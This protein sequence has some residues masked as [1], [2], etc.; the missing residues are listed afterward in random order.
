VEPAASAVRTTGGALDRWFEL[1]SVVPLTGF[2]LVHVGSYASVLFGAEELGARRSPSAV[3][4]VAE[5]LFVWLPFAFHIVLAPSIWSRRGR[6]PAAL[7]SER[8]ALALH[9]GA[10]VVLGGFL[11]DHFL[12]FRLPILRGERYPA[13]ALQELAAELSRTTFGVPL[14]AGLHALGVC[15]L[16]FHLAYGLLRIASR[17]SRLRAHQGIVAGVV[18]LALGIAVLGLL[19]VIKLAGG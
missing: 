6:A 17:H 19:T 7:P 11:L 3:A 8:A 2:V 5:A 14:I 10:G 15:A 4:L 12:R 18:C 1:T 9:R 16:A 13:E